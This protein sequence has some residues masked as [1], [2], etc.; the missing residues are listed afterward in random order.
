VLPVE[1]RQEVCKLDM[2]CI[3]LPLPNL[4]Q[5]FAANRLVTY[6]CVKFDKYLL[7]HIE[8]LF[9]VGLK[10]HVKRQNIEKT[11]GEVKMLLIKQYPMKI[12]EGVDVFLT[13]A[14][15]GGEC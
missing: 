8:I 5:S 7:C 1:N 6:S 4:A 9:K 12:Y 11:K 14:V 2:D 10:C 15:V 13:S 3:V